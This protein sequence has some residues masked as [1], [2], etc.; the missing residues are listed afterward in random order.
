MPLPTG[1]PLLG[2][3]PETRN[4]SRSLPRRL[5]RVSTR[6]SFGSLPPD[7]DHAPSWTEV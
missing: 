4:W 3:L 7:S 6:S 1:L 2:Q 5:R